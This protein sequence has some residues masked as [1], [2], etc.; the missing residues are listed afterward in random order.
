MKR[1]R[2]LKPSD[3]PVRS[4]KFCGCTDDRACPEGCSWVDLGTDVCTACV[5]KLVPAIE[6]F[7][8]IVNELAA[9]KARKVRR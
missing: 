8:R 2:V 9:A 3:D 6:H 1:Q 4:C 5:E 7:G